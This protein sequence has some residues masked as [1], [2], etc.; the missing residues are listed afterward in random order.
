MRASFQG[1]QL[2]TEE[3][4]GLDELWGSS[5]VNSVGFTNNIRAKRKRKGN[6]H[7]LTSLL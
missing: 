6:T 2:Y 3:E 7:V 4:F 1:S 5:S